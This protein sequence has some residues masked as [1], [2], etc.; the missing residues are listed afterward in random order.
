MRKGLSSVGKKTPSFSIN[1]EKKYGTPQHHRCR[2]KAIAACDT[3]WI[4]NNL[5]VNRVHV[6]TT[7]LLAISSF[8][9]KA[10]DVFPLTHTI[11]RT[12]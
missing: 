2:Q 5:S 4:I 9:D 10:L 3:D 1:F 12:H 6:Y 7:R 8:R 11:P